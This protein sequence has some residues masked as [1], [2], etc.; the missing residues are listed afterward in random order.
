MFGYWEDL[1]LFISAWFE[2][3]CTRPADYLMI[4]KPLAKTSDLKTMQPRNGKFEI[5]LSVLVVQ[6]FC[7]VFVIAVKHFHNA[8]EL[9]N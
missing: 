8:F 4:D 6:A 3:D 7:E 9:K 2:P 5:H 1:S